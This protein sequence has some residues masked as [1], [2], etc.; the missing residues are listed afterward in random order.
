MFTYIINSV[1]RKIARR[2]TKEYPVRINSY[3]VENY[4]KVKFA[5]WEN[6]LFQNKSLSGHEV[7]FFGKFL[8]EGDLAIDIGANIGHESVQIALVTGK[9][10]LTLSF[11][12][13]PYVYKIL[14]NNAHLN[15]DKTNIATFNFAITDKEEEFYYHSSEATFCNGGI[16]VEKKSRHGKYTFKHKIKGIVLEPFLEKNYAHYL[17][18]LKLIK[19]DTEGY[20]KEIIKSISNLLIKYKPVVITECFFR[21]T[22]EERIEHFNLLKKIGYSLYYVSDFGDNA[23]IIPIQT[24]NDMLNWKH[25]DL[26]AIFEGPQ[27]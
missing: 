4:G 25:F 6:P 23:E 13:N 14:E 16:S 27:I 24:E 26:Y 21:N 20:D 12:P 15:S 18:K 2:F 17:E 3:E 1:K 22:R 5:H 10:G 7:K 9:T 8:K 19:I 11:D